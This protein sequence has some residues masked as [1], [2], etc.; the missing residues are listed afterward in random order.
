MINSKKK[1]F[2]IV[3][4][5]IVIAVIAVL[6]AVLIP[7][8][9]NLVKKANMSADQQ[10]VRQMNTALTMADAEKELESFEQAAEALDK[11]GYNA[12]DSLIPL[13][14]GYKFYWLN[15]KDCVVL[16]DKDN[17][18]VFPE[19]LKD[20]D[21]AGAISKGEADNLKKGYLS[22]T[23]TSDNI[24]KAISK[25]QSVKLTADVNLK[26]SE[27]LIIPEGEDVIIDL[28]GKKL[29]N[30]FKDNFSHKQAIENRGTLTIK[31][32]GTISSRGVNNYGTLIIEEGVT[33]EALD[34][35][36]GACVWGFS[37]S[38]TIINGGVF[39]ALYGDG[40]ATN[41]GYDPHI[42]YVANNAN[43]TINNGQFIGD[44]FTYGIKVEGGNLTI[45]NGTFTHSRGCLAADSGTVIINGGSFTV[46]GTYD[47]PAHTIYAYDG[48]VTINNANLVN[49]GT[50]LL[51]CV[52]DAG[53]GSIVK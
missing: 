5:V 33:I 20:F 18:V 49:N 41:P 2:T 40:T 32:T 17:N 21:I 31:G 9:S 26:A 27:Q 34:S 22:D 36:G 29:T 11:A 4:L 42:V 7:T 24:E 39:E 53:S 12:F 1:G 13:T 10:A 44:A 8:F 28:N 48:H 52:D 14:T 15:E 47:S 38:T 16:V 50:G 23:S 6:A 37:G 25:G 30:D 51:T 3:E 19:N 46:T 35:N 45:N 43:V